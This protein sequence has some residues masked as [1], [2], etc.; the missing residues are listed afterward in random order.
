MAIEQKNG[1]RIEWLMSMV[2][3]VTVENGQLVVVRIDGYI[4]RLPMSQV[5]RMS[6]G[7]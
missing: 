6:I 5:A 1:T 3:K 4:E 7:P 2:K